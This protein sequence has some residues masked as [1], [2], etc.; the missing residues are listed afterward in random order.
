M[1]SC[2]SIIV[3]IYNVEQY[4]RECVDSILAQ[5]YQN[6]E[7][8]LVDD[9]SPDRC[10]AICDEYA[11]ADPRIK[12]IHKVNGGLSDARNAGLEVATGDYIGFV[13]SDDWIAPDMFSYLLKGL[14]ENEAE[15]AMCNVIKF[16]EKKYWDERVMPRR[17]YTG[18]EALDALFSDRMENY[19]WNKL[20]KAALWQD[21]RFPVGKNFE[22]ILTTYKTF[23]KATRVV[24]LLGAKYY[25]RIRTD[26]ISGNRGFKNRQQ[27]YQA[28]CDR[29]IEAV[30]RHPDQRANL[31][32]RIQRY[33]VRELSYQ[34]LTDKELRP[35]NWRLLE[36]LSDFIKQNKEDIYK[37]DQIAWIDR[38]KLNAFS[39]CSVEGCFW[40]LV[41]QVITYW[42][43][44]L[45]L[46]K[47]W[48]A[49]SHE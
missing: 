15:I 29:Y 8:I 45:H 41:C 49:H 44:S 18:E 37:S 12:V 10:G 16:T 36:Q 39:R 1:D 9:G 25:Y 30:P 14:E 28:I 46:Y 42:G 21:I 17:V 5:S 20:Y 43:H 38:Q 23:E 7:I 3:P 48:E 19:A 22:D 33:Y 40:A 27:I 2:I 35:L 34:V 4:L 31:I 24:Q 26:S 11:A 13:D 32:W 47:N 6:L